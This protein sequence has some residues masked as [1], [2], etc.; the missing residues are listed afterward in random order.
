[1]GGE[2]C[3][4][5]SAFKMLSGPDAT[6]ESVGIHVFENQPDAINSAKELGRKIKAA[7]RTWEK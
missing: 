5:M 1:M 6:V 4:K 3:E 2:T 7:L